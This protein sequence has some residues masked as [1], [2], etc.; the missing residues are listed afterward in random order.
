MQVALKVSRPIIFGLKN[1]LHLH[2][3]R[4]ESFAPYHFWFKKLMTF[5]C[6]PLWNAGT[7]P[8]LLWRTD[9]TC[10]SSVFYYLSVPITFGHMHAKF[11][12]QNSIH[13]I[14]ASNI[15]S[16]CIKVSLQV[17]RPIIFCSKKVSV[18]TCKSLY[19]FRTLSLLVQKT[20]AISM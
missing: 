20:D 4:F 10:P 18:F 16:V 11:R 3:S 14:F 5:T 15:R 12:F 13:T 8:L 7:L 9:G 17:P 1:G 2:A 19:K 6:K